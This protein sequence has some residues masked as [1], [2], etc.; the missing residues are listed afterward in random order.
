[1]VEIDNKSMWENE[2]YHFSNFFMRDQEEGGFL[3]PTRMNRIVGEVPKFQRGLFNLLDDLK[4]FKRLALASPR[5]FLKS[6]TCSI[7]FP[8]QCAMFKKFHE[9]LIVSN[10]E[11]L[12]IQLLRQIRSNIES[13]EL[14][15]AIFGNMESDK[16]TENHMILKNGVSIRGCGWGAQIRGFRP[17]L[18][19]LDDIESDETVASDDLRNKLKVWIQKSAINALSTDGCLL[20]I[21]TV[22]DRLC[23]L[24]E[25]L[26]S[27]PEGWKSVFNQAY[28]NAIQQPGYELWPEEKP[29]VWLQ[30]RKS[31]IGSFAFASEFLNDPVPADGNRFNPKYLKYFTD[32]MLQDR[33]LGEYV[34]I[35]PSFSDSSSADYGVI[36]NLLH[37]SE[38][39][40]YV[41]HVFREKATSGDLIKYFKNMYKQR[42]NRIRAVG[43]ECNGPQKAFYDRLV[44]E[45]NVAGLYPPFKKLT[46]QINGVRNKIDRITFTVQPRLE[47]GKI[48][49]RK[50]DQTQVPLIEELTLFPKAKHDDFCDTL[51]YGLSMLEPFQDYENDQ[52]SFESEPEL[53]LANRGDSGYGEIYV[54]GEEYAA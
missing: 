4:K 33:N 2:L 12:A 40:I 23:I 13:N 17:D 32:D 54:M 43:V 51:A 19:I 53:S 45:C 11:A 18:I 7:F 52:F 38:A 5:G 25:F 22:I 20:F 26:Q 49:F 14:L 39:N 44:E 24:N 3:V 15:R 42:R 9:I 50:D 41:D 27:P 35:D 10:S 29:H 21:G 8:L 37:D 34:A 48:Y 46:G 28:I 47:A 6:T 30:R 1:M 36:T 16:W 31:E